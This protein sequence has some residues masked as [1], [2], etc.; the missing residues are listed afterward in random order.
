MKV[1]RHTFLAA[2]TL[3]VPG[4]ALAQGVDAARVPTQTVIPSQALVLPQGQELSEEE[5]DR[6]EG[7]TPNP[8]DFAA[9]ALFGAG[10][11]AYGAVKA[12]D[13]CSTAQKWAAGTIGGLV[14]ATVGATTAAYSYAGQGVLTGGNAGRVAG[15]FVARTIEASGAAL[16]TWLSDQIGNIIR[17]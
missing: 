12:C 2:L 7:G 3:V 16:L 17:R 11:G 13:P 14:G 15:P 5:L 6:V 8:W 1:P 9:G 10:Y 4:W